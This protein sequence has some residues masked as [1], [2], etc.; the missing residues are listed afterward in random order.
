MGSSSLAAHLPKLHRSLIASMLRLDRTRVSLPMAIRNS[1]GF[2]IPL[3]LLA[4]LGYPTLGVIMGIGTLN[5]AFADQAGTDYTKAARM[6][7]TAVGVAVSV[8]AGSAIGGYGAVAFLPLAVWGFGA[9]M[10][11]ALGTGSTQVGVA[12]VVSFLVMTGNPQR[13]IDALGLAVLVLV[14]GLFQT[15]LSMIAWPVRRRSPAQRALVAAF[16]D[17]AVY[18]RNPSVPI[19]GDPPGNAALLGVGGALQGRADRDDPAS[20]PDIDQALFDYAQRLQADL[21]AIGRTLSAVAVEPYRAPGIEHV[22]RAAARMLTNVAGSL[23]S[24]RPSPVLAS[25]RVQLSHAVETFAISDQPG[26]TPD[27]QHLRMRTLLTEQITSL[28]D[29]LDQLADLVENDQPRAAPLTWSEM[30]DDWIVRFREGRSTILANLTRNSAYFRHALRLAICLVLA[31]S[32]VR[33]LGTPHGYWAPMTVAII[34]RP[35]FGTTIARGGARLIGTGIGLVLATALLHFFVPGLWPHVALVIVLTFLIRVLAPANWILAAITVSAYVVALLSLVGIAP[36]TTVAQRSL[37]T[38]IGGALALTTFI[39]WP[40]WEATQTP[41]AL[42]TMLGSFRRAMGA[43]LGN[44]IST[45]PSSSSEIHRL[46]MT[47]RLARSNA[48][49]SLNRLRNEPGVDF[50]HRQQAQH[51]VTHTRELAISTL[52]M[53]SYL[54][55]LGEGDIQRMRPALR[56]FVKAVDESLAW[57]EAAVRTGTSAD[58]PP[59]SLHSRSRALRPDVDGNDQSLQTNDN[60]APEGVSAIIALAIAA[61]ARRMADIVSAMV[62][63]VHDAHSSRAA[64]DAT[65]VPT[66]IT[67]AAAASPAREA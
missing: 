52:T 24:G 42:A 36:A 15:L 51:L 16:R 66:A 28:Q 22:S 18:A 34:L 60:A 63:I 47:S 17:L 23:D 2:A 6:L 5:V 38:A 58:A 55:R 20:A 14:G 21:M 62:A 54:N 43:T 49:A 46:R 32:L 8:F 9:G 33:L 39:V 67:T 41:E 65:A 45:T 29:E 61:E 56:A 19:A 37:N 26:A 12:A 7:A 44:S 13:P 1:I 57:I 53:E 10:L 64:S 30:L 27:T 11:A 59:G 50:H 4:A 31:D 48:T 40:T 35:D 3:I 25:S